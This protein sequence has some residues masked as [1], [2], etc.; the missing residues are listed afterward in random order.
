L[1]DSSPYV[2]TSL[3]KKINKEENE[4]V[5]VVNPLTTPAAVLYNIC[6]FVYYYL[7]CMGKKKKKN[8]G[9]IMMIH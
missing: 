4:K 2:W 8:K 7:C 6:V 1:G 9:G 3:Q 5:F